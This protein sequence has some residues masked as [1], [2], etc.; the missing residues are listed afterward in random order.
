MEGRGNM[1]YL[2]P[3]DYDYYLD[4]N[5]TYEESLDYLPLDELIPSLFF[6]VVIG[7]LG[8][9]GNVL[10]IVAILAFPRMKSITNVFL[11]SLASADLLLVLICVPIKLTAFFSYTW[12][13][14]SFLCTFVAYIQN[15]SMICS[16]MTLTVMSIERFVAILYPL[17]ARSFCTM[18]HA[19]FVT[20]FIWIGSFFVA[21]PTVFVQKIKVVGNSERQAHWCVKQYMSHGFEIA[22][23]VYMFFILFT[24][25][26]IVMLVT[27]IRISIE[28]WDVVSKRAVLRSGSEY[29]YSSQSQSNGGSTKDS[30]FVTQSSTRS[31]PDACSE[32]A[33]TR[34]QV[35]LMLMVIV[36][37][38][39]I[40]WGPI[41]LNNLLVAAKVIS[42]LHLGFL[43]PMR[44]AFHLMSYAN[45]CVN[46][47][48]YGIMS[49][50][51][52]D[53]LKS[54]L[55]CCNSRQTY[56][57][58]VYSTDTTRASILKSSNSE[59]KDNCGIEMN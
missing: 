9:A 41:L 3:Y 42:D 18:K 47:I 31:K 30:S 48:V 26:L 52:Q 38:F 37:L 34:K 15:V 44:M 56:R 46:P 25:P 16:V 14:G 55:K 11:L 22:Y 20:I 33:K 5:Y 13:L 17:Q 53:S 7:L 6:Y 45:S 27:Y 4:Y 8:I 23:E 50:N 36:V 2:L 58:Y 24:I 29:N 10:V 19:K 49:K 39:A 57:T 28:I 59:D 54:A 40:C 32:D 43:K 51:F 21:S 12:R 1:T 35:I